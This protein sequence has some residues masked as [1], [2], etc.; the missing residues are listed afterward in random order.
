MVNCKSRKWIRIA[1][2]R[3][4]N[5]MERERRTSQGIHS[6]G[7]KTGRILSTTDTQCKAMHIK[8]KWRETASASEFENSIKLSELISLSFYLVRGK[9]NAERCCFSLTVVMYMYACMNGWAQWTLIQFTV[10]FRVSPEQWMFYGFW[11][12]IHTKSEEL[13]QNK[14][15][16]RFNYL[17]YIKWYYKQNTH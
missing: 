2:W 11:R 8:H 3:D 16:C 5:E 9:K 12:R 1:K 13:S 7:K 4:S 14:I 15:K 10:H 6:V 17:H